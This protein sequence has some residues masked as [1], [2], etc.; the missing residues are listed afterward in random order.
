MTVQVQQTFFAGSREDRDERCRNKDEVTKRVLDAV[1]IDRP[2][3]YTA[4]LMPSM[5]GPE[6][7]YL[8]DRGVP[9]ENLF[10]IE[11]SREVHALYL[12]PPAGFEH[13]R[14]MLTTPRAMS[15]VDAVDHVPFEP[16]SLVY[17]DFFGQPDGTHAITLYKLMRLGVV[18]P[19][20]T[21]ITTFGN[22][23][24]RFSCHLNSRL[25]VEPGQAYVESAAE[26]AGLAVTSVENHPYRSR[27]ARF[28]V[29]VSGFGRSE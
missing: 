17:L 12:D 20:T 5:H 18:A 9:V 23:G 3:A 2:D 11:R 1:P 22:R 14:G 16:A 8:R 4:V 15:A 7:R 19:G 29:T 24:D 13:F 21:L 10:A 25:H 28:V 27:S 26:R 6:V